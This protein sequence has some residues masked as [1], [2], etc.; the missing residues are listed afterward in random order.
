MR[1]YDGEALVRSIRNFVS[2]CN[3][4]SLREAL[5]QLASFGFS[6][7]FPVGQHPLPQYFISEHR[8]D[9]AFPRSDK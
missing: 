4:K 9:L 3:A 7:D 2:K 5:M 8:E 6:E 1:E